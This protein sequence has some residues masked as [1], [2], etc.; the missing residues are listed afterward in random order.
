MQLVSTV[1]Q[2]DEEEFHLRSFTVDDPRLW[3][4]RPHLSREEMTIPGLTDEEWEEFHRIIAE[5]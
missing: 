1:E 2:P 3:E 4:P 5:L